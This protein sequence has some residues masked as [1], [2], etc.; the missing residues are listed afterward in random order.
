MFSKMIF[1]TFTFLKVF[2]SVVIYN[3]NLKFYICIES[4]AVKGTVSEIVYTGPG[5]FS[6]ES[7]KK[8]YKIISKFTPFFHIKWKLRQD[9]KL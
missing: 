7:R 5:S 6:K 4:I 9:T 8:D 1:L 3:P 2:I